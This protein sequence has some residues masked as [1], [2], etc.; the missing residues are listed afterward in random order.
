MTLTIHSAEAEAK[1]RQM[2]PGGVFA[3]HRVT[4]YNKKG[5]LVGSELRTL[6][7]QKKLI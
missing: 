1:S 5:H 6:L 4:S 2:F 3:F 7:V